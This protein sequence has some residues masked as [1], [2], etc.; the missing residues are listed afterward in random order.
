LLFGS[1][2]VLVI[3]PALYSKLPFDT[4]RDFAPVAL[5]TEVPF[6]L[7]AHPSVPAQS[8]KELI[9]FARAHP[10]KLKYGSAGAGGAPHL[11]AELMKNMARIDMLHVPYKGLG[12]ALTE[13]LGGQIDLIFAGSN[14]VQQHVQAGKLKILAVTGEQ[15]APAMPEVPTFAESG[16]PGYR[17]GTWYGVLAPAGTP[18]RIVQRLN[19]ELNRILALAE[20]KQRLA[21]QG[22][23]PAGNTPEQFGR[24]IRAELVKWAKVVK[25]AGIKLE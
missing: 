17:A 2:G 13:L 8:V 24:F 19:G 3:S 22:A 7:I 14:L 4:V 1:A 16:L 10:G 21:T 23:Q 11:A 25:D 18:A 5:M 20:I 6:T 15:R 12:P 9:E